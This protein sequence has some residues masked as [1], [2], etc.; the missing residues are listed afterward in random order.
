LVIDVSVGTVGAVCT[1]AT[2]I[3]KAVH[4]LV[5]TALEKRDEKIKQIESESVKKSLELEGAFRAA[6]DTQKILFEKLDAHHKELQDYKLSVAERYVAAGA[7]K[8]ML[9]P[10][11]ARLEGIEHDLRNGERPERRAA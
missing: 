9:A 6:R 2:L 8:E 4:G 5:G 7:L 10:L 3:G 11:V 1:V